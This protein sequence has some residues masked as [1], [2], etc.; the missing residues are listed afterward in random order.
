MFNKMKKKL[1]HN[2]YKIRLSSSHPVMTFVSGMTHAAE[3]VLSGSLSA[4]EPLIRRVASV[5]VRQS[6]DQSLENNKS[7]PAQAN[8]CDRDYAA[9]FA[10]L[11]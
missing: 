9:L 7:Y 5:Q 11:P 3:P 10:M 4:H 6:D 8:S 2:P 1:C